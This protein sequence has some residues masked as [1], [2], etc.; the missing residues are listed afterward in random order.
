MKLAYYLAQYLYSNKRLDLPGIGTFFL[1]P[2][3]T[4]EIDNRKNRNEIP[5][6]ISF[7]N[8]SSIQDAPEL[9]NYISSK[10]GKMK[11]L[12]ESDL[13]SH[14]E[15]SLQLLNLNKPVSFEGIG[16]LTKVKPG[17][18]EFTQGDIIPDKPKNNSEKEKHSLSKKETVE[19]KYQAYLATPVIRSRWRKPVLALLI[20]CGIGLAIWGGYFISTNRAENKQITASE[21][22][23]DQSV[24]V[25]DTSMLTKRA[26]DSIQ[27]PASHADSFKYVL[28]ISKAYTAFKRYDQLKDTKLA[29]AIQ[30]ETK[31]SIQYKLFVLLPATPDTSRVI[32]SLTAFLGR[33]VY[34]EHQN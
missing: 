31:D 17:E 21:D 14:L 1:D 29:D 24:P 28:Q 19:E 34:I 26:V 27:K 10:T 3:A 20:L 22:T 16:T 15:L 23:I 5:H 11:A 4:I 18:Y 8:D 30:M 25:P 33:K 6:G 32:D 13:E 7:Q 12:A 2:S 9:V